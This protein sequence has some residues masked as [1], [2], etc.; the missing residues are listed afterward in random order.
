MERPEIYAAEVPQAD[1]VAQVLQ[2]VEA[3]HRHGQATAKDIDNIK[4]SRQVNYYL[5]AAR[6]LGFLDE[7]NQIWNSDEI[8]FVRGRLSGLSQPQLHLSN[9]SSAEPGAHGTKRI[10]SPRLSHKQRIYSSNS[11]RSAL[12]GDNSEARFHSTSLAERTAAP[13]FEP[14]ETN[15]TGLGTQSIEIPPSSSHPD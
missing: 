7:E 4:S 6:I 3:I 11:A 15:P 9:R 12:A 2:A 14:T 13:L 1:T 10:A 5:Q 8:C